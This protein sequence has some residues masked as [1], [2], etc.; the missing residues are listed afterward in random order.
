M[1]GAECPAPQSFACSFELRPA[2]GR[3][4]PVDHLALVIYQ[5]AHMDYISR[6]RVLRRSHHL[7]G[8]DL[9]EKV[10]FCLL[11]R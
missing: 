1:R 5:Q 3:N 9:A 7:G 8:F 2:H 10:L 11:R 6:M 4:I